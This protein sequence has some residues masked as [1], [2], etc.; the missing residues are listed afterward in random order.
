M[1][2]GPSHNY[3]TAPEE[4]YSYVCVPYIHTD[5]AMK[6]GR[7]ISMWQTWEIGEQGAAVKSDK[8][9]TCAASTLHRFCNQMHLQ[10]CC[11]CVFL[12]LFLL[13]WFVNRNCE[14]ET[15]QRVNTIC[16]SPGTKNTIP[17]GYGTGRGKAQ[18]FKRYPREKFH[19]TRMQKGKQ[20][21]T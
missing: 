14:D 4:G 18:L 8:E 7:P 5:N 19:N 12:T 16:A 9:V 17:K 20:K 21:N 13:S 15:K 2:N 11:Y 3:I 1:T 6:K 10:L